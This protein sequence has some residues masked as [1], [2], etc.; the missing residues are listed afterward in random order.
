MPEIQ[1]VTLPTFKCSE[2][3]EMVTLLICG[4]CRDC[5][6]DVHEWGYEKIKLTPEE[7]REMR[8]ATSANTP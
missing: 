3:D 1:S 6:P 4:K 2:C 5:M 7:R 8:R